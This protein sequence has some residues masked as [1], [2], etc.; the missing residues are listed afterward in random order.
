MTRKQMDNFGRLQ[1]RLGA[2]GFTS[3]E[4]WKLVKIERTL[5][6]W[7]ALECGDGNDRCS[8]S[9]ER[10]QSS[11]VCSQC[12]HRGYG[13][14]AKTCNC[15]KC[16]DPAPVRTIEQDGKPYFVT[17]PHDGKSHRRPIADRER[18]AIIRL[19]KV[20]NAHPGIAYFHQTDPR[21]CSLYVGPTAD[22]AV[23]HTRGVSVCY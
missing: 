23:C 21:G 6:R 5:S 8:W 20:L 4:V 17:Y 11:Y 12:G 2:M 19:V 7:S 18:G 9:I 3:E 16:G 14:Q 15:E 10:A 22:M 13:E 1:N